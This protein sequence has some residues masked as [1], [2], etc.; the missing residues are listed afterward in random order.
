M[1]RTLTSHNIKGN[2]I[3]RLFAESFQRPFNSTWIMYTNKVEIGVLHYTGS[4]RTTFWLNFAKQ[5]YISMSQYGF[6]N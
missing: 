3:V 1:N 2:G 6:D 4:N 5:E